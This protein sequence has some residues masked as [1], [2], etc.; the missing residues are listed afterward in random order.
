MPDTHDPVTLTLSALRSDVER[1]PLADSRGVRRR[2]DRRTRNQAVGGALAVVAL[3]AG[4]AGI[5]G[6]I[7]GDR[8]ATEIP[9]TPTPTPTQQSVAPEPFLLVEDLTG[10]GGYDQA[11]PFIDAGQEPDIL[12]EQCATRPG[13]W[14][15]AQIWSTR[16]Y[17]DGSEAEIREYVLRF[18]DAGSA[19]QAA[20]KWAY[21][22]LVAACPATV[23]PSEGTLTTRESVIVPGLDGAVQHSRYF[24]PE[25]AS[26]PNYYEV[27]T[28]HRANV[29]VVLEWQGSGNPMLDAGEYWAWDAER[30]QTA[31]DRAV[32]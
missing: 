22:D 6:G 17:Q 26:E 8:R 27:A 28:A 19:E 30:L 31:L 32:E 4:A 16:Y 29:V 20:L 2:G 12:P 1:T 13:G 7:D 23:D 9:A 10:F 3:V 25:L 5:L 15:A 14:E 18:D 21:A 24:V 11:G